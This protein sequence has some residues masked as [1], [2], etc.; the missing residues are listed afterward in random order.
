[1][2]AFSTRGRGVNGSTPVS[3]TGSLGSNP[4]APAS[5]IS[6]RVAT[7]RLGAGLKP[8]KNQLSWPWLG[9]TLS[10]L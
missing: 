6:Q 4:S 3:K 5:F 7:P 2:L 9:N 1:M 8:S 10:L